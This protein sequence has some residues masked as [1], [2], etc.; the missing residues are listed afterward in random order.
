MFTRPCV[1]ADTTAARHKHKPQRRKDSEFVLAKA[2][3]YASESLR[4][5]TAVRK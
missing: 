1:W 5:V 2:A 4:P 3:L